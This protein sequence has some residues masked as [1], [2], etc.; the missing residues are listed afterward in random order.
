M[1]RGGP[2]IVNK[3][4]AVRR[5]ILVVFLAL[6]LAFLAY[7]LVSAF[8]KTNGE[9]PSIARLAVAGGLIMVGLFAS[10]FA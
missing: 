2:D 4:P 1:R 8:H 6:V 7:S 3:H 5:V 9:L 10:A